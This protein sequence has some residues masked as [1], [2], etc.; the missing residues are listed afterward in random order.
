MWAAGARPVTHFLFKRRFEAS[1]HSGRLLQARWI[2]PN[3]FR[4][5]FHWS[6]FIFRLKAESNYP[7]FLGQTLRV[8]HRERSEDAKL[9]RVH[10]TVIMSMGRPVWFDD[11]L[12]Q[13]ELI[14][15]SRFSK[16]LF[17]LYCEISVIHVQCFQFNLKMF[18]DVCSSLTALQ[19]CRDANCELP[20]IS[21][22]LNLFINVSAI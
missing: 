2:R 20:L 4:W 21:F 9:L 3:V 19:G 13:S 22:H 17:G 8:F 15:G 11:F 18:E 6:C 12:D 1:K 16:R 7:I 5:T 14:F 10:F